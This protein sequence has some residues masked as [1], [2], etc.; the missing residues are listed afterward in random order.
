MP[1]KRKICKRGLKT[2]LPFFSKTRA[3][4]AFNTKKKPGMSI[5]ERDDIT[6]LDEKLD[7][8]DL[9]LNAG[10]F[11]QK[12]PVGKPCEDCGEKIRQS[13]YALFCPNGCFEEDIRN[14]LSSDY[15]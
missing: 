2:A 14:Y 12:A 7:L 13:G 9:G 10:M 11:D 6:D 8:D 15:R 1:S 4:L 5:M 3:R